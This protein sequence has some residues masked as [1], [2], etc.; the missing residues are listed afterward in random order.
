MKKKQTNNKQR[1]SRL[2]FTIFLYCYIF[3]HIFKQQFYRRYWTFNDYDFSYKFHDSISIVWREKKILRKWQQDKSNW[4]NQQNLIHFYRI[5]GF[6][7]SHLNFHLFFLLLFARKI[8]PMSILFFSV[9]R[10]D[11]YDWIHVEI[12][13]VI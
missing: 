8:F 12:R 2:Q 10:Y 3:I 5:C 4:E 9:I 6:V 1:S 11:W 7:C 13:I